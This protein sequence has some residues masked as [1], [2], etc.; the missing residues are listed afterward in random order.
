MLSGQCRPRGFVFF[1]QH[2]ERHVAVARVH[3][4]EVGKPF[5][6]LPIRCFPIRS[7]E[8]VNDALAV[9][10]FDA[11]IRL[12]FA[13]AKEVGGHIVEQREGSAALAFRLR[14]HGDSIIGGYHT[15]LPPNSFG[16]TNLRKMLISKVLRSRA[17]WIRTSDLLNPIQ[18]HYQA[19]LRPE[20]SG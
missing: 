11:P 8:R 6:Q 15:G 5:G 9:H 12:I 14:F 16:N 19:V 18:A 13:M 10:L 2:G 17:D 1:E 7:F 4:F 3:F 20:L